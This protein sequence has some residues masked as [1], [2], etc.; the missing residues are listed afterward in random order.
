MAA[1]GRSR[2]PI[3][4]PRVLFRLNLFSSLALVPLALAGIKRLGVACESLLPH[5]PNSST[6]S[7]VL[8]HNHPN[9]THQCTSR[10]LPSPSSPLLL[11]SRP[12]P[13][14]TP[15]TKG[16][17][18]RRRATPIFRRKPAGLA[19]TGASASTH[20]PTSGLLHAKV[21]TTP[22]GATAPRLRAKTASRCVSSRISC[23]R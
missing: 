10:L 20:A 6:D 22:L 17:T 4:H 9:R 11:R 19:T 18:H 5:K 2:C 8:N 15:S 16:P 3:P 1:A 13:L 21:V 7:S 12:P 23:G 14:P